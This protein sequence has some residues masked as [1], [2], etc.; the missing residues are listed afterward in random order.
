MVINGGFNKKELVRALD[1]VLYKDLNENLKQFIK[2]VFPRIKD[3]DLVRCKKCN[4]NKINMI[5][6]VNNV[7]KNISIKNG[8]SSI[9]YK[10]NLFSFITKLASLNVSF[11]SLKAIMSYHFADRTLD[12][13]GIVFSF[14]QMLKDDFKKETEMVKEE[15]KD[16][17]LLSNL[18]NYVLIQ[19]RNNQNVDYFY[20]GNIKKGFWISAVDLKN[21]LLNKT[22]N[23]PHH[24]MMIGPFNFV[25]LVR[26]INYDD[27]KCLDKV[28]CTLKIN[29]ILK[30]IKK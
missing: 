28:I 27:R 29:N 6:S 23:F 11:A 30:Y 7:E 17:E 1:C 24:F 22:D 16:K 21:K 13:N 10:D 20:Y 19:E 18:I 14:G 2:Y 15:F 12:G 25:P 5:V 3:C 9:I 26:E 8:S 4:F